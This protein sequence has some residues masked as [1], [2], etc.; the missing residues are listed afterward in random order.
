M[1]EFARTLSVALNKSLS[2][3]RVHQIHYPRIC[4]LNKCKNCTHMIFL[5]LSNILHTLG[6]PKV[7]AGTCIS[8]FNPRTSG[9]H[10]SVLQLSP[11]LPIPRLH[12]F[13]SPLYRPQ[14][15]KLAQ[16]GITPRRRRNYRPA[17]LY[18]LGSESPG[19]VSIP[20]THRSQQHKIASCVSARFYPGSPKIQRLAGLVGWVSKHCGRVV[21]AGS[22]DQG[23]I[24]DV[25]H[26]GREPFVGSLL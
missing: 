19:S 4:E 24:L 11:T 6:S 10:P 13:H 22:P 2:R 18:Q 16:H 23:T 3:V 1:F 14:E 8:P 25:R 21:L 26:H 7:L 15:Y 9:L 12:P 5:R 20:A 17:L